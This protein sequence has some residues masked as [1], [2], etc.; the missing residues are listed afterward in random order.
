MGVLDK[1]LSANYDDSETNIHYS[2]KTL[3]NDAYKVFYENVP[4]GTH[5]ID[6]KYIKDDSYSENSDCFKFK[7]YESSS[8]D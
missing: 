1:T 2:F 8:L 7:I 6:I 3:T 4:V 5:F